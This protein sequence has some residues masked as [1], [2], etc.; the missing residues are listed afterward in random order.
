[1]EKPSGDTS[2]ES[3][4]EDEDAGH[5][6]DRDD[7]TRVAKTIYKKA[8]KILKLKLYFENFFPTDTEKD[9]LPYSCW[10]SAVTSIGGIDGGSAAAQKMFY[11]SGFDKK[12]RALT[13]SYSI[14]RPSQLSTSRHASQPLARQAHQLY[15]EHVRH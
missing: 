8:Y 13:V 5:G 12:V 10:T 1:M 15:Q 3:D 2:D 14:P 11:E 9:S 6:T 7:A 4:D